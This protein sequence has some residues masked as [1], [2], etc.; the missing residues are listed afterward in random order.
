MLKKLYKTAKESSK[1]FLPE[2]TSDRNIRW[3]GVPTICPNQE[4]KDE[5]MLT[6]LTDLEHNIKIKYNE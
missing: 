3:V 1:L 5:L 4:A 2:N 6:V